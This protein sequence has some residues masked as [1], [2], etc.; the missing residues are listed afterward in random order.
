MCIKT[1]IYIYDSIMLAYPIFSGLQKY[2]IVFLFEILFYILTIGA[3]YFP[4]RVWFQADPDF[5]LD[6]RF[7]R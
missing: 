1:Y 5:I 3:S 2:C 4:A 6:Q 7:Q